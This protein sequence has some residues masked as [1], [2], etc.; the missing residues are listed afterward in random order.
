MNTLPV[1]V[2]SISVVL[3]I[4]QAIA[5]LF[6]TEIST[7]LPIN[8][9]IQNCSIIIAASLLPFYFQDLS[10]ASSSSAS[11]SSYVFF[12]LYVIGKTAMFANWNFSF[13]FLF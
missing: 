2:Y 11:T 3:G 7:K 5:S 13:I 12:L 10:K 4:T 1:D 6:T 8:I 9:I